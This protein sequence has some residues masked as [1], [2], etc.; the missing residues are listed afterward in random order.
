MLQE[1][2]F[3]IQEKRFVVFVQSRRLG[4]KNNVFYITNLI[5]SVL[6]EKELVPGHIIDDLLHP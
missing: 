3:L 1:R 2:N 4:M 5:C 6:K